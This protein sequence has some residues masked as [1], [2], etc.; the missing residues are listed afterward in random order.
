MTLIKGFAAGTPGFSPYEG[1]YGALAVSK[2]LE[3]SDAP[4]DRALAV[5]LLEAARQVCVCALQPA[6]T[7]VWRLAQLRSRRWQLAS[8]QD[9]AG[10]LCCEHKLANDAVAT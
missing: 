6:T 9:L 8:V 10:D 7:F 2:A 4:K 1:K 3:L 5:A